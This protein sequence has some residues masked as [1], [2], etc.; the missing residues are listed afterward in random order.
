MPQRI[1]LTESIAT[2]SAADVSMTT[3]GKLK[4]ALCTA[5]VGSSGYYS[6][7]VLEAAGKAKV[8]P[9]GLHMMLN[10]V[11]ENES[12]D[13]RNVGRQVQDIAAVLT[14][15]ATWDGTGLV[16][17]AQVFSP[18]RDVIVEMKDT[19]GVSICATA[20]VEAGEFEGVSMPIITELVEGLSADFVT[21]AG[22]GGKILQVL[23]SAKTATESGF[24]PA[25]SLVRLQESR[26]VGQWIESRMHLNFT[27]VADDMFGDGRLSREERIAMS[28]AVGDALDAFTTSLEASAP[29]LYTRDLWDQ[30]ETIAAAIEAGMPAFL[31]AKV[32]CATCKHLGSAHADMKDAPNTG[33]CSMKGCDC[34]AMKVPAAK[35][36]A[37]PNVPVIPAGP[38][39]EKTMPQ[40]EEARLSQLEADSSRVP[41]LEAERDAA[42]AER[43]TA[44]TER[45]QSVARDTAR[46]IAT[47]M[48]GESTMIP[49]TV[50]S[51]VIEAAVAN[52]TLTEAGVF[53]EAAFR[54]LV[55]A[56]RTAAETEVASIAEALGV[57][58]VTSFGPSGTPNGQVTEADVDKAVASAFG[59]QIT[60]EA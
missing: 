39:K 38:P 32:K 37:A 56:A 57:G 45:A 26:N 9:Q 19:I 11:G 8:F 4:V 22:R 5:G 31:T 30:P 43:D 53:D 58:K 48:V 36:S 27:C 40:I 14:T 46:P 54:T 51:R 1:Q 6:P 60:K 25:A 2:L 33:A 24:T 3:S 21:H 28:G 42:I 44:R 47:T 15:D 49:A 52:V 55:E 34:P 29:Q 50:A 12:Y 7:Q 17:E 41:V 18:Y 16:A 35:E 13:R 23:E 59:H 10:H 20:Q